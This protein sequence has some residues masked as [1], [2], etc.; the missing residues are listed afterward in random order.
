MISV[1][2]GPSF[3]ETPRFWRISI[4]QW[5]VW[6]VCTVDLVSERLP[7]FYE[8]VM[9][10]DCCLCNV[11]SSQK[12]AGI[13]PWLCGLQSLIMRAKI[14]D[15]AIEYAGF[16]ND[17]MRWNCGK[18]RNMRKVA[19][20]AKS[21]EICEKFNLTHTRSDLSS[22]HSPRKGFG[23]GSLAERELFGFQLQNTCSCVSR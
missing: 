22:L 2:C 5:V 13:N 18:L 7:D 12:N 17:F 3:R 14:L 23:G 11:E 1:H 20:Y 10:C 16:L 15:Y 21:C 4:E 6:S 9:W 19:K 8:F